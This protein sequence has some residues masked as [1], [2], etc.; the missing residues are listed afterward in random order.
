MGVLSTL[1]EIYKGHDAP[2]LVDGGKAIRFTDIASTDGAGLADIDS[3]DVVALIGDYNPESIATLLHLLDRKA[4]VAPLTAA[5]RVDHSYFF[6]VA[7]VDFVIED[8]VVHNRSRA[9][10]ANP[11]LASVREKGHPGI[12]VFSSGTTGKPKGILHDFKDT[13]VRYQVPRQSLR[14]INFLFFDHLGGLNTLFHTL[15]NKGMIARPSERSP[16]AIIEDIRRHDIELLPTTPT[17]LRMMLLSGLLKDGFPDSVKLVTYGAER[18]DPTT[19]QE[20]IEL[21]PNVEF[22]QTYGSSEIGVLKIV[23]K[24]KDSLWMKIVGDGVETKVV[25]CVLKIRSS[26]NRMI[27]YLNAP[28][29]FDED[30]WFDTKDVVEQDGEWIRIVGRSVEII[31]VGGLKV[32]PAEIEDCVLSNPKVI[33]AQ[34]CAGTNPITGEHI[35]LTC[36]IAPGATMD[37]TELRGFLK[38]RLPESHLPHR[39][40]FS[41][42]AISHRFKR[43]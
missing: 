28:S 5:T 18:M 24:A 36:E 27:G 35:E 42:V 37:K 41:N 7:E 9:D 6:D 43:T 13:M 15:F 25:D 11:V 30:G 22:R 12:V 20:L 40:R 4:I 19:L 29:P 38:K 8:G 17:F 2:F 23:S 3:G 32:F 1:E 33:H 21:N 34:V 26:A 10:R 31:N 39:I 16:F 14:T